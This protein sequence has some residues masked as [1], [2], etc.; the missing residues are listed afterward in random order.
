MRIVLGTSGTCWSPWWTSTMRSRSSTLRSWSIFFLS[1]DISFIPIFFKGNRMRIV[2]GTS[3]TCCHHG[4]P[5]D[6][7]REWGLDREH[8][9]V[10]QYLFFCHVMHHLYFFFKGNWVRIVLGTSGTCWSPWSRSSTSRSWSIFFCHVIHHLYLFFL[11]GNRIVLGTSSTW[12][13]PWWTSIMRSRSRISRTSRSWSIFFLSCDKS[14]IPFFKGNLMRIVLDTSGTYWSP[15]WVDDGDQKEYIKKLINIFF[16]HVIHHLYL[17]FGGKSNENSLRYLQGLLATMVDVDESDQKEYI[18][19]FLSC[20]T[21]YMYTY[22]FMGNWMR[23][24]LITF[25][26]CWSNMGGY[27][28]PEVSNTILIGFHF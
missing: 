15:L 20:D 5:L 4:G 13:Y 27:Y 16:C 2:I 25:G 1:C 7:R 26:T 6:G 11:K 19:I 9:E 17:F 3:G 23:R 28:V 8:Q 14:F 18:N 24:V 10:Y 22:S 12:W 21:S